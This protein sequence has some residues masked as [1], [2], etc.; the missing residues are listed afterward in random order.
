[1]CGVAG[2]IGHGDLDDLKAMMEALVHRGPDGSG[3]YV[4][5]KE[6]LFFGHQRLA[7]VDLRDGHQPMWDIQKEVC[8]IFN[9]E[10]YNHLD[11][12]SELE[13]L[14]HIFS[15]SHSDTEVLIH[16][17]KQWRVKL[18]EKLNGMF[19]F[20]IYDKSCKKIILARDRF[21][22]KPLYYYLSN[23]LFAF[24]SELTALVRHGEIV[25]DPDLESLK[26]LF[27]YGFIP[28]PRSFWKNCCK[29]PAGHWAVYDMRTKEYK[30][31]S[32]WKFKIE[33]EEHPVEQ[34]K[35]EIT[36]EFRGL[37]DQAVKRRLMSDV[38]LGIFLS[39]GLDSSSILASATR[40]TDRHDIQTFCIG[41]EDKTF[42]ES[43][44][45]RKVARIFNVRHS[46]K[47]LDYT[48]AET[49]IPEVL[50]R[51]D[52]PFSD[53]SIIPTYLL[54]A[55]A[56][57]KVT[58][59]LSGDGGDELLAGYD[60]FLA[61]RPAELYSSVVPNVI[62]HL[63]KGLVSRLPVSDTNMPLSFKLNQ[64]L[65]G[66][67]YPKRYW[68]PVWLAPLEPSDIA[69]LFNEPL[70]MESL[71]QEVHEMW[72]ETDQQKDMIDRSLEFYTRFYL[73]ESIL[74]KSDRATMLNSLESR[75]VFL[76]NDLVDFCRHLPNRFKIR[77]RVRKVLLRE[78]LKGS[79]PEEII[80][81]PKK[82]FGIPSSAW[83][84]KLS[85][86]LILGDVARLNDKVRQIYQ[87]HQQ[88]KADKHLFLWACMS[89]NLVLK[90]QADVRL[91]PIVI[92]RST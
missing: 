11:L 13:K 60:P 79:L 28:A 86:P 50:G 17:W 58:V 47:I 3:T 59:A 8:V 62:H 30:C 55:F 88:R 46:E 20:A 10:I 44:F 25:A 16:G 82:G 35:D 4:D 49:L 81:R 54:S 27:A 48:E 15:T 53:A 51:L 6:S 64:V 9:G 14:G 84:R 89:A 57:E 66:L 38:P 34:G 73:Q 1:V 80:N 32:Y 72:E 70:N 21:G 40:V 29:L 67:S 7:V 78:T 68:N 42:D 77:G 52:E 12:R 26:K 5:E 43:A 39:G 90:N 83:L 76:D 22:E 74:F 61:I 41:F 69:D 85:E 36:E 45:A 87:S 2:F 92:T 56:R 18:L 33:V 19:A 31:R 63:I 91:E 37:L 75:A 24:A 23:N 71:Y 65:S